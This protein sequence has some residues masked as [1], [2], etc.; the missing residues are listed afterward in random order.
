MV[1]FIN[2][3]V[4]FTMF[5]FVIAVFLMVSG[6]ARVKKRLFVISQVGIEGSEDEFSLPFYDRVL[7]PIYEK[8]TRAL[9]GMTPN[10]IKHDM[11]KSLQHAGRPWKLNVNSFIV[12]RLL[13][14]LGFLLVVW[15]VIAL[16]GVSVIGIFLTL[17]SGLLGLFLPVIVI[18]ARGASRKAKLQKALPDFLDMLYVS[19]EAGLGFDMALK[20]VSE[21]MPGELAEEFKRTL[22]E[23]KAGRTREEAMR[24]II[25]RTGVQDLSTFV[26]SVIQTEQL[27]SNI[28]NT[29]RIQ[30]DSMRLKRKQ[31]AE[32]NAMKAPV[33]MLFPIIFF[34]FPA[35]FVVILGPAVI[36]ILE[37]FV[38][39]F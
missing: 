19:V 5:S 37:V 22:E 4:F 3:L 36:R 23:I 34:I 16:S 17:V 7:K 13:T 39:I 8:I 29:L 6:R 14:A 33:K 28:G 21:Q 15:L 25:K 32:A 18:N 27:G 12:L 20:R 35:L 24:N 2:V 1:W 38:D 26:S 10:R 30:A 31:R 9:E 11:E